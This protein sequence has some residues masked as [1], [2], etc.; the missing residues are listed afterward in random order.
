[1]LTKSDILSKIDELL[2]YSIEEIPNAEYPDDGNF[3]TLYT[4]IVDTGISAVESYFEADRNSFK[5]PLDDLVLFF[6]NEL[7]A[8]G[9]KWENEQD[10]GFGENPPESYEDLRKLFYKFDWFMEL[11]NE[12][13]CGAWVYEAPVAPVAEEE[14]EALPP[15][16]TSNPYIDQLIA[17]LGTAM[18]D[19]MKAIED[20]S[21]W[22][23]SSMGQ[24][25]SV[26][27]WEETGALEEMPSTKDLAKIIFEDK[28]LLEAVEVLKLIMYVPTYL[29]K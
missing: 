14:G 29:R 12:D 18:D 3:E 10:M 11:T 6:H 4:S 8:R 7:Q 23:E 20:L 2:Q 26:A 22:L 25:G 19:E 15:Q 27:L 24:S 21:K 1:M 16:P 9:M 28:H 5:K 13:F 17:E